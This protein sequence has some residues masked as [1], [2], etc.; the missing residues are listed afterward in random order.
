MAMGVLT[1]LVAETVSTTMQYLPELL[2][3]LNDIVGSG[4]G[5]MEVFC[6]VRLCWL[7]CCGLKVGSLGA[8]TDGADMESGGTVAVVKVLWDFVAI[9]VSCCIVGV[10]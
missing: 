7:D 2:Q 5:G 1:V 8:T 4:A 9:G 10:D 3:L 6:V